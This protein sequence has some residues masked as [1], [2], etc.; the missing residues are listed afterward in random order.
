MKEIENKIHE[1][2]KIIAA[3]NEEIITQQKNIIKILFLRNNYLEEVVALA[4]ENYH[5]DLDHPDWPQ[6]EGFD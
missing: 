2:D 1:N 5:I 3:L 4:Q 6:W